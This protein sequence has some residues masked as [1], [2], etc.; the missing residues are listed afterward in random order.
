MNRISPND[1]LLIPA[2]ITHRTRAKKRTV[3]LCF[4]D[5]N[6]DTIIIAE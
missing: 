5:Q 3:N 4:E 1:T 2:G 6:A